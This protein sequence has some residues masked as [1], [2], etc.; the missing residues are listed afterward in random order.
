MPQKWAGGTRLSCHLPMWPAPPAFL[1]PLLT[2]SQGGLPHGHTGTHPDARRNTQWQSRLKT[3]NQTHRHA[4]AHADTD[5]RRATD[6]R[7]HRD[8]PTYQH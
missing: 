5:S 2:L 6:T 3:A 1:F 8:N 4:S 7:A